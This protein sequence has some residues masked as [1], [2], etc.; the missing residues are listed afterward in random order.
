MRRFGDRAAVSRARQ[1]TAFA[2][3][4]AL[5]ASA[6]AVGAAAAETARDV[7]CDDDNGGIEVPAGFCAG[8]FA[9]GLLNAR[10][11][12]TAPNGTVYVAVADA[13][14]GSSTGGIVALRDG[15][16][17]GRAEQ[18]QRFGDRGGNGI[19]YRD[20][21]LYFAPNDGVVRY[22]VGD[23]DLTPS[24]PP[25]TVVSGLPADGDHVN[26]TVIVGDDDRMLVNIGSASNACQ[27]DN[28]QVGSPGIDPCPELSVRAGVWAFSATT[29]GQTA[30]DGEQIAV[31]ARNM[32]A[33]DVEP[34]TGE[35]FGVQN[36]RDQLDE[37]WP[38]LYTPTDDLTRPGEVL[39]QLGGGR[40]YGWPYCYFDPELGVNVLAPEY[41]G[42]GETVGRCADVELPLATFPAHWAPLSML[43]TSAAALDGSYGEGAF[44]AFHGSR[45]DPSAQPDG[46]G[47]NVAFVPFDDG[48]PTGDWSVFADGFA[49][50]ES[51]LPDSA[52]HRPV[53]LAEG[54]DG[55]LYV[56]DDRGGRIWRIVESDSPGGDGPGGDD[57]P[58]DWVSYAAGDAEVP[59]VSSDAWAWM[60]LR[61]GDGVL[62][63]SARVF[64]LDDAVAG[65]LHLG[66]PGENGPIVVPLQTPGQ[67]GSSGCVSGQR[68]PEDACDTLDS[69]VCQDVLFGI[70]PSTP[71][72][73]CG[74][75]D[76]GGT[77]E[78]ADLTGALAGQGVDALRAAVA[79]GRV[80][81]NFHTSAYPAGEIRGQIVAPATG[82]GPRDAAAVEE[83][84]VT[85][86]VQNV[87]RSLLDCPTDG[88]AYEIRG[89]LVGPS[90]AVETAETATLYLH[91]LEFGQFFWTLPVDGASFVERQARAGH[92]SVVIDRL[93]YDASGKPDGF[94]SCL[95][96]QADI[97]AQIVG[98]LR[99]GSYR[100]APELNDVPQFDRVFLGGH[101]VGGL[102]SELT[103][104]SFGNVDGI[105]VASYS[106]TVLGEPTAAAAAANAA[107]CDAGGQ[108]T[109]G[110]DF[111]G[112]YAPFAPD[113]AAFRAAFFLSADK[114]DIDTVTELRNLN[115]C[116]DTASF[117]D[118]AAVNVANI[119]A[120]TV[121]VLVIIGREDPLFPP[122]AGATQAS[123]FTGS[124]DVELVELSP[125]SHAVTVEDTAPAFAEAIA[126]WLTAR[127]S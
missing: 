29:L 105:I 46:P 13:R 2:V 126:A 28:R 88:A 60:E 90:G 57:T 37:N 7:G 79:A 115:P 71:G 11:M 19:D 34:S 127:S 50:D 12:V 74:Y 84:A 112:G 93:G 102:L 21:W 119:T 26:K 17:D 80:Y 94:D 66:A 101:S 87:N 43:F 65:H 56:S 5:V 99:D 69:A 81:A 8:V 41:G 96:G 42:D 111:P 114:A 70:D 124:D 76:I 106:D 108:R 61:E 39:L 97:T 49:G 52:E 118:A 103:A 120:I 10:Q 53:G 48:V 121:P 14:D 58:A 22:Q 45:F 40:D 83:R 107:A 33:L 63:Y 117:A 68:G 18:Q 31:G 125:S 73:A 64:G 44:V 110:G 32:V 113:V 98:Q 25:E 51:D 36:G 89:T 78:A 100:V 15:D 62:H 116:G 23:G 95:G 3:G 30:A 72:A 47:Y 92:V 4:L 77:I 122:P 16:G 6:P 75:A 91:G 85:F 82:E 55:A 86:T 38:E 109:E 123:L 24:G 1:F 9:E 104:A 27:V 59:A 67:P 54:P 20:G 35:L